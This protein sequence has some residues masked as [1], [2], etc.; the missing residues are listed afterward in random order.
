MRVR[1]TPIRDLL[2][3]ELERSLD[4]RGSFYRLFCDRELGDIL[5]EAAIVQINHSMT[6]APGSVRG[7]HLQY[8]PSAEVKIVRCIKGAVFDVAVDLRSGSDNLLGWHGVRLAADD[9]RAILIPQ[10]F[11]HGF[12]TIDPHSELLYLHSSHYDSAAEGG[13]HYSDPSVGVNWPLDVTE[14]SDKD[15]SHALLGPDFA[16]IAV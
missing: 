3:L 15:Q 13:V 7:L 14:V 12:Q 11:A 10:G 9:D 8:P 1:R 2:I 4:N 6:I 16:G 5:G